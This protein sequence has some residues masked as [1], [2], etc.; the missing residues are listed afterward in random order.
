M[1]EKGSGSLL[2]YIIMIIIM[3]IIIYICICIL[4]ISICEW[5]C[6]SPH[7]L[8]N[9]ASSIT[10]SPHGTVYANVVHGSRGIFVLQSLISSSS[11]LFL[12][13]ILSLFF[14]FWL[15]R[16]AYIYYYVVFDQPHRL[17]AVFY[18]MINLPHGAPMFHYP[19]LSVLFFIIIII[20]VFWTLAVWLEVFFFL[21]SFVVVYFRPVSP[22]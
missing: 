1:E 12:F 9:D 21:F 17:K 3:I 7:S 5:S 2:V 19:F 13:S 18:L 4:Y 8:A 14:F 16:L 11:S 15:N 20:L 22:L 10:R 6:A